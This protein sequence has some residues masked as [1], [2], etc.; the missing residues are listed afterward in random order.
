MPPFLMQAQPSS[1][2]DVRRSG[3][4]PG[5]VQQT[6]GGVARNIA[7][8]GT[9]LLAGS[10]HAVLLMSVVGQDMAGDSLIASCRERG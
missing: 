5:T 2:A 9:Q 8:A 3:S 1:S 10:G 7:D 4:V 6:P